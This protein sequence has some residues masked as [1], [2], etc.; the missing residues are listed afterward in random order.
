MGRWIRYNLR[1]EL[2]ELNKE[3]FS[4]F[5]FRKHPLL[6]QHLPVE[7]FIPA[8]PC[9]PSNP[10]TLRVEPRG[11]ALSVGSARLQAVSMKGWGGLTEPCS[12]LWL[13]SWTVLEP[14]TLICRC[15][16]LCGG[17][18]LGP[19]TW[20]THWRERCLIPVKTRRLIKE[21]SYGEVWYLSIT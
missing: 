10:C 14:V 5:C 2:Q 3:I 21:K 13:H 1:G 20:C 19:W 4:C 15:V 9:H 8:P 7:S 16:M 12:G 18:P 11:T 6:L 17:V